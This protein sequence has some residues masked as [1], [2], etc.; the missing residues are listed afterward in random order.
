MT[1]PLPIYPFEENRLIGTI[2]QVTASIATVNLP[3][4]AKKN[5]FV[6]HGNLVQAGSVG[7]YVVIENEDIA[8][9]GKIIRRIRKTKIL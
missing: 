7:E 4:A 2:I 3:L 6:Y 1:S 5:P 9:F 8:I